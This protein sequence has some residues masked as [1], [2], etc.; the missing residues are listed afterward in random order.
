MVWDRPF[1]QSLNQKNKKEELDREEKKRKKSKKETAPA[2]IVG[3]ECA[4]GQNGEKYIRIAKLSLKNN[5]SWPNMPPTGPPTTHPQ[6]P[7]LK[8][9]TVANKIF[10][11]KFDIVMKRHRSM[12]NTC[13]KKRFLCKKSKL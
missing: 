1:Y 13:Q 11:L 2:E 6:S 7:D 4:P 10:V 12:I 9:S 5:I 3:L 8:P